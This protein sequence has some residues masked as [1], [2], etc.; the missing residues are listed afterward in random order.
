MLLKSVVIFHSGEAAGM[1]GFTLLVHILYH[2]Y[3]RLSKTI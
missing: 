1:H 3:P 2:S